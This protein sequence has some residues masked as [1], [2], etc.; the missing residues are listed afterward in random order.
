MR[1]V[2]RCWGGP[3]GSLVSGD[4]QFMGGPQTERRI[5]VISLRVLS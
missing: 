1:V 2:E 3:F 4:P 5:L